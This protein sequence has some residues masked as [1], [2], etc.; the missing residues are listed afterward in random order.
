MDEERHDCGDPDCIQSKQQIV[1]EGVQKIFEEAMAVVSKGSSLSAMEALEY[2]LTIFKG[3][4]TEEDDI[5]VAEY[6]RH[7]S[8]T[9]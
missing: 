3:A 2:G 9:H 6:E 1:V 8:T 7:W 4:I 5:R